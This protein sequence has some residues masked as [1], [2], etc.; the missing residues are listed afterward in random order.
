MD[1]IKTYTFKYALLGILFGFFFP[2]LAFFIDCYRLALPISFEQFILV[3]GLNP[4][5]LIIDTAP[6]F[7]GLSAAVAGFQQDKI[8]AINNNLENEVEQQVASLKLSKSKL[9]RALYYKEIF[10]ANMSHEIRTPM[11]GI[12]GML[13]L[14]K[15]DEQLNG[16]QKE[17]I[18]I[19]HESSLSL[20]NILND[21]L[22]LTKIEENKLRILP[23]DLDLHHLFVRLV[24]TFKA[25]A[26]KKGLE[27]NYQ[28]DPHIN[29]KIR[30]DENRL[31]QIISNLLGNALKFT[32]KGSV[33]ILLKEIYEDTNKTLY[34][35]EVVDTGIG[36]SQE[37]IKYIF[38]EFH[39]IDNNLK[40]G[41][42]LG[43]SISQ[44]LSKLLG[45]DI[46]VKS[47]LGVGSTFSFTFEI[48]PVK[49]EV[50]HPKA[51]IFHPELQHYDLSVLL[52]ED[53][54]VN[55]KVAALILKKFGC[56][57]VVANNGAEALALF[58]PGKYDMI[59]MDVQMPVMDGIE[60]TKQFKSSGVELPPIVGLSANALKSD[61][62]KYLALGMD[63]YLSKPIVV[64]DIGKLLAKWFVQTSDSTS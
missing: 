20:M 8:M 24:S 64:D 29:T 25:I 36:I 54:P 3:Q 56:T 63:D 23:V 7:L 42:G 2:C 31:S 41:T 49:D 1:F 15:L 12:I 46:Y 14:L 26:L 44:K 11:N 50:L 51:T 9:E 30:A 55:Q 57:A 45:G 53:N 22:D 13:D 34:K 43:L 33:S 52:V 21:V 32:E 38:D 28:I 16:Q 60:T 17:Y 39:Q 58:E 47:T 19:I 40:N 18:E 10:L 62:D 37:N 48:L 5:H 61:I 27:L 6:L 4:I 35:I 59:L